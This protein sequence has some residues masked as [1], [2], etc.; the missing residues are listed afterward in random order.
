[1]ANRVL[2]KDKLW[3]EL[4]NADGNFVFALSAMGTGWDSQKSGLALGHAYSILKATEEVDEDGNKVRLVQVRNPWGQR[5]WNGLGEWNGPWSDG[6]KEWTAYWLKKLNHKFGDDGIF[7][8]SYQ[9]MLDTFM[10]MHRTRLFDDKWTVVQ[11]W[12][13]VNIGWVSGYLQ[14]KFLVK[15]KKASMVVFVLTQLDERFFV[16]LEGQYEFSLHFLLQEEGGKQTEHLCRVR[17]VHDWENRSVS[18]EVEL[19]PGTYQVLPKITATRNDTAKVVE[20]VVKEYAEKN[21]QKLRQ[22][23]MNY[24]LAHAKGGVLDEDDIFEKKK[25]EDKK[26]AEEKKKRKAERKRRRKEK[27]RL[28]RQK[29]KEE[30]KKAEEEA[31]KAQAEAKK[32]EVEAKK[33]EEE[34]KKQSDSAKTAES[35]RKSDEKP[36]ATG[37]APSVSPAEKPLA[38]R[39][40]AESANASS[41]FEMV[42]AKE[43]S[44]SSSEPSP[45]T[46]EG[47]APERKTEPEKSRKK[48]E[49]KEKD[50]NEDKD[51]KKKEDKDKKKDDE[52]DD[53]DDDSDDESDS[54]K[55][56]DDDDEDT[57]P[58]WNAVIVMGLRVYA[59]DPDVSIELV[60]PKDAQEGASLTVDE[61]TPAGATM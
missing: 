42:S 3:R 53:D 31:K 1:M 20:D 9:S 36:V 11:Q 58:P 34:A 15:L 35:G 43:A 4:V 51:D 38:D 6:S 23:G 22:I 40:P 37:T 7:W 52:D 54:D 60:T 2:R 55:D 41:D 21:P 56:S 10:F 8:M 47:A 16:G 13:S 44:I 25:A 50:K 24:D 19:E 46:G 30:A 26:K 33:A 61:K 12:T 59:M 27:A 29:A 14:R 45:L 49:D 57:G 18:C 48:D 17:P 5:S 39:K 28:E 32:A